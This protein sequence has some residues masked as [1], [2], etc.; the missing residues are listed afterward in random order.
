MR[1]EPGGGGQ[2]V[3]GL[4]VLERGQVGKS[5]EVRRNGPMSGT[6]EHG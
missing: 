5:L 6:E 1:G 2:E 4:G 3:V